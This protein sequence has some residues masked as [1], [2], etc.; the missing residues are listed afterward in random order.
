MQ[1]NKAEEISVFGDDVDEA[2]LPEFRA[3][4]RY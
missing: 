2:V 3:L 1:T 4:Y